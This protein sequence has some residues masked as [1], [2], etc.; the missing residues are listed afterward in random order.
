L[1]NDQYNDAVNYLISMANRK[2]SP[3]IKNII[4]YYYGYCSL[5][6]E[7][8]EEA[9]IMFFKI[10]FEKVTYKNYDYCFCTCFFKYILTYIFEH[11]FDKAKQYYDECV[12]CKEIIDKI[13]NKD[14]RI[15]KLY[16]AIE[17]LNNQN[18]M[19]CKNE[20]KDSIFKS[21]KFIL[22]YINSKY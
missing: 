19:E 22:E 3:Y 12:K 20:L 17:Y 6:L 16:K 21:N 18:E 1:K 13:N 7:K 5:E 10:K 15:N 4:S 2:H 11:N 14:L 8:N 9:L